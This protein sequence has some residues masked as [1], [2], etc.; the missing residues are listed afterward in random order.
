MSVLKSIIFLTICGK[1]PSSAIIASNAAFST[2]VY[3]TCLPESSVSAADIEKK[4][5]SLLLRF[6]IDFPQY[7][8]KHFKVTESLLLS[9]C[10]TAK[11]W[12]REKTLKEILAKPYFDNA[13]KID[14]RIALIQKEISFGVP[15]LLKPIYDIQLPSNMFLRFIEIG[16]YKPVS[17]KMIELNIPRETAIFLSK[18]Y[19]EGYN[20]IEQNLEESIL[21]RLKEVKDS[22]NYWTKVQLEQII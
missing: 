17:R 4:L 2:G 18:A 1:S 9:A 15:M 6:K 12:M 14:D 11:E 16:A 8:S 13:D 20:N 19:F 10:I 21:Q 7:Y 3:F 22:V 5:Q